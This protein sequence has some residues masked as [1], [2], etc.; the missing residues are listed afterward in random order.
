MEIKNLTT[1]QRNPASMHIDTVSTVEM[2]KIMNEE[3]QKVALAVGNQ[4]EQI[5]RAIDEAANRYKKDG[6]LIY[7]GAG[8]SGRLGVLDAAELVP[9]YGIKPERAIGLIAGGPGAMYKAVEGAEDDTNLGA[10][11]LKDLNLNSQDIVLGLAASGRTPYVIGG[12]EYANQIGAFTISIACVKDSEIGKHA[13]VAI[14]AVVG[15]EIVTGS[16]RM[17]SGTAQKMILNMIS[18]GVMIRQG[19]VFENVMIDV[20]PTNSKL[21]DR[22]SRIISAVTDATQEEALQTL[23]KAE[24]NVPLAITMIKTESNKDEAQKLLE[25]YNGNVSEVIKNN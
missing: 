15:P 22:A 7:L 9:T 4:D 3:D 23:K 1:E 19:K 16:T 20:M 11:D 25:Q 8:T 21:V 13:K 17:K 18:T 12:L 6:R 14:E 2:V 10:E 5:A 24:N